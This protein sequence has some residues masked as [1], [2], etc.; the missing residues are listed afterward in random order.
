MKILITGV[1]GFIGSRLAARMA[2]E[3]EVVGLAR[4]AS[5][6]ELGIEHVQGSFDRFED[7]RKLDRYS[8]DM[9]IHL[10]AVTGGCS[11]EDGLEV[12]VQ[13]TRRLYRYLL[14][15]GCRRFI[16]ASS[17]AAVGSLHDDFVPSQLPMADDHPCLAR[18]MYGLSKAMMEELI[19]YFHRQTPEAEFVNLRFGSV[20]PE[21]WE[22]YAIDT[23]TQL[24]IPFILLARVYAEDVIE[25]ISTIVASEAKPRIANYNLVGP[26]VGSIAPTA[27][28]VRALLG[29]RAEGL[30][31]S[32]YEQPGYAYKP[33][34][35]MDKIQAD[36]G[37]V[38][39]RDTRRKE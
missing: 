7:L 21:D 27:E 17:I 31:L 18:D 25:G 35:S 29:D 32:Y 3:H 26:D 16:S 22:P 20:V 1:T 23:S 14:D 11:E 12:N 6:E 34:Y 2:G 24:G 13:G 19:G 30:D 39:S 36:Y 10:A 28:M 33:L 4:G 15:R 5:K 8:F 38:P 37:F 9:V